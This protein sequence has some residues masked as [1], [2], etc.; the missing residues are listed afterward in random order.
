[1]VFI[2]RLTSSAMRGIFAC[3]PDRLPNAREI[4]ARLAAER[5]EQR[6]AEYEER[7]EARRLLFG[8]GA[9]KMKNLPMKDRLFIRSVIHKAHNAYLHDL[10]VGVSR[11][12]RTKGP[13]WHKPLNPNRGD[14][15]LSYQSYRVIWWKGNKA[16]YRRRDVPKVMK[17]RFEALK[18]G[19]NPEL[20]QLRQG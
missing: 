6:Q 10:T 14:S 13:K 4:R 12:D 8:V 20:S 3:V 17:L 1:M 5:K 19:A 9:G 15:T 11:W 16:V 2:S 18:N 7:Y